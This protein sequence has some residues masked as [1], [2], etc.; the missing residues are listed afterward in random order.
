MARHLRHRI[1]QRY[2]T[3]TTPIHWEVAKM[4]RRGPKPKL[5]WAEAAII[6]LSSFG[7]AVVAPAEW[8]AP[9]GAKVQV[10][11]GGLVGSVHVRRE[12]HYSRSSGLKLYGIEFADNPSELGKA[13][14]EHL[15]LPQIGL[16]A[17]GA[18]A[19]SPAVWTPQP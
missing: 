1:A 19:G 17:S 10:R 6:E 11:W 15:V 12:A 2:P 5:Q 3:V 13:L 16:Q 8:C 9:V 18:D 14:Y 7:A 4:G